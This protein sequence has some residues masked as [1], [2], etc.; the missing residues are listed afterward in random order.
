MKNFK[1]PVL[2]L[3]LMI[4]WFIVMILNFFRQDLLIFSIDCLNFL[5]W[6]FIFIQNY[7]KYKTYKSIEKEQIKKRKEKEIF[8]QQFQKIKNIY[9]EKEF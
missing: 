1:F 6:S 4:I 9:Y 3:F 2:N 5:I 8:N 7:K